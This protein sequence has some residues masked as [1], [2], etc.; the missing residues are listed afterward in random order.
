MKKINVIAKC[1]EKVEVDVCV[2]LVY[3]DTRR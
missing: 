3:A 1:N 2:V